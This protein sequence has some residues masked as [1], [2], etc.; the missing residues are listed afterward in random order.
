MTCPA[1][2]E[3]PKCNCTRDFPRAVIEIENPEALVLL[4][5][6]SIPASMGDDTTVPPAVGKYHNVILHY[7]ANNHT[8]IYSSDGIPTLL[9]MDV[10]QQVWDSIDALQQEID[11]MK[12]SP[13]VVDIVDTYADL[14]AYDTS[15]LG[16]KDIIRVLNDE[17]HD[18]ESTYYRWS[19]TTQTWTYIGS[20][21]PKSMQTQW[22]GNE[23]NQD[24][25]G[26]VVNV[27]TTTG[28]FKWE[29]G[30]TVTVNYTH[31]A[32][33]HN[34]KIDSVASYPIDNVRSLAGELDTGIAIQYICV[35]MSNQRY[36]RP[37][38]RLRASSDVAGPVLIANNLTTTSTQGIAL[39]ANQG[40]V[41]KDAIDTKQNILTF[42]DTP[43][44]ASNNPVKSSGV[45]SYVDGLIIKGNAAPTTSTEGT[46]GLLYEDTSTGTL[47]IL[48]S[49]DTS[50]TPNTYNWD[51]A[52]PEVVQTPGTSQEDVMSQNATTSMIFSDPSA[53]RHIMIGDGATNTGSGDGSVAIGYSA[54]AHGD[55]VS[56][57]TDSGNDLAQANNQINIGHGAGK[58][59]NYGHSIS[60]G[61]HAEADNISAI[62]IG[63]SSNT[64][65]NA[66]A[67]KMSAIAIGAAAKAN[68]ERSVALGNGAFVDSAGTR[69][70]SLEGQCFAR[71]AVALGA[72]SA[73]NTEGTVDV[74]AA[75]HM[76][77]ETWGYLGSDY[78]RITGVYDGQT[79]HDAATLAQG[80]T[81]SDSAPTT[82]TV[83]VLGQLYT[84]TTNMHTYQCTYIDDSDPNNPP[85]YTWTQRW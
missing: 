17:T 62:A 66:K 48:E 80:N 14:M 38:G 37:I 53:R 41:L 72:G 44:T 7:E 76:N 54:H 39:S 50:V 51:L 10:P 74:G 34:L 21:G 26:D 22:A 29:V 16:D 19:I 73:A 84:D 40:K 1:C 42:D 13:D 47:Y 45:K 35:T 63:S 9:E 83:G 31:K 75:W 67:I 27:T 30:N 23:T 32:S 33:R 59:S 70:I 11:D 79:L 2:G 49:I 55:T 4:R 82:S 46:V 43:T 8:Y 81:L 12:N 64:S 20:T 5:K 56:I 6:V 52:G 61:Y 3:K 18:G 60:I 36:Y 24:D 58:D 25:T 57:G 15:Q 65:D 28:D 71:G 78:R 68:G 69:S 85:L 77:G